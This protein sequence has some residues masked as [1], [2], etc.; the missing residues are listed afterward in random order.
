M[1]AAN[2]RRAVMRLLGIASGRML[3]VGNALADA[4]QTLLVRHKLSGMPKVPSS[5]DLED[6]GTRR[7]WSGATLIHEHLR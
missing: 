5:Y 3:D 6:V 4:A 1:S 2:D 7:S